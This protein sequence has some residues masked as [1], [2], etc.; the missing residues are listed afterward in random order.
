MSQLL[1]TLNNK[2]IREGKSLRTAKSYIG[3]CKQYIGWLKAQNGGEYLHPNQAGSA[4]V[5]AFLTHLAVEQNVS[6]NTQNQAF[7]GLLYLYRH[8]GIELTGVEAIRPSKRAALPTVL[9]VDEV[10]RLLAAI[11]NPLDQLI[12][13][14]LYAAGLRPLELCRLRIQD[15]DFE[16]EKLRVMQGKGDV[17][18]ESLFPQILH[19]PTRIQM[20]QIEVYRARDEQAGIGV[21][22][23]HRLSHKYPNAPH[24]LGWYYLFAARFPALDP[25]DGLTKRWHIHPSGLNK[26]V[27]DAALTAGFSKRVT[28]KTLRH[29]FATHLLQSGANI[30]QVQEFMGHRDVTTTEIYTH[31]LDSPDS[32]L[33][34]L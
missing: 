14:F 29:S 7:Y 11:H 30:R 15:L 25:K 9:T 17:S 27:S 19:A 32:P 3:W 20:N 24:A 5:E 22:L 28:P 10:R 18:R 1:T 23:P 33:S 4:E 2:I 16:R 8:L 26:I 13:K 21:Y 12:V 31:L 34:H 6:K